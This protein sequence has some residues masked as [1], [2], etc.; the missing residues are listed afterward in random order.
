MLEVQTQPSFSQQH[1]FGYPFFGYL[2]IALSVNFLL[3]V[4]LEWRKISGRTLTP[5][6][7]IRLGGDIVMVYF[8]IHHIMVLS[9]VDMFLFE[10]ANSNID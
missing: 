4:G 6:G 8:S 9:W 7:K 3:H 1:I 10:K 5:F 2:S